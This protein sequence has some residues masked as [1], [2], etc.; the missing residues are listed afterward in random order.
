MDTASAADI[1]D[2]LPEG[3]DTWV[4]EKGRT[5]SGGQ[6]QRLVLVRALALD[7]EVLVLVEPTSA[8]D[9]H[10]EAR[11]AARLR[12]QRAGRITVVTSSSPLVLGAVDEVAFLHAGPDRR[13]RS[14]RGPARRGPR[15]PDGRHPRVRGGDL[16]TPPD[17]TKL[18]VANGRSVRRYARTIAR[19]YPR[20][21][22]G[23]LVLH[24]LAALAGLAAP[25]LIGDLVESVQDGTT[26]D[27]VD[28]VIAVLAGVPARADG[29]HPLRPLRQPGARR[30]GAGRAARGLRREHARAARRGGRVGG[31][32]RPAHPHRSRRRPAGL[33][34][35]LGAARVDDRPGD[36][37]GHLRR[38]A[39]RRACGSRSRACSA[40]R[41]W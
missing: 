13:D 30:A 16:M 21:L 33:V 25:R 24:V 7:P 28:Q 2:G 12:A 23:A 41:R 39:Q 38:R 9:A 35:A 17:D 11:I 26:V 40:C 14:A 27:H 32:R 18:P 19:Q 31:L 1:L 10:T 8:V 4:A 22:W 29:A 15:L 36:R 20:M 5:F 37:R 6:R 3:F 34:G